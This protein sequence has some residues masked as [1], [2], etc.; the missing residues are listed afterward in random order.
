[1]KINPNSSIR[2]GYKYEDLFTLKLCVDWLLNPQFYRNIRIQYTPI[3][4][5]VKHFALDDIVAQRADGITE[6]Y[7]I[8]HKQNP[9]TDHWDFEQLKEKGLY[10][11]IRSF[12]ALQENKPICT[13]ITNGH[14]AE[15]V[16]N[17]SKNDNLCLAQIKAFQPKI[18]EELLSTF[19]DKDLLNIFFKSFNFKFNCANK[20][21]L[22]YSLRQILYKDLKVTKPGVDNLLLFIESQGSQKYP[23][24]FTL[25]EIRSLLSWDN[26]RPLNQNFEIP[27]DFEFFDKNM[28]QNI[29][30]DLL[31]VKGGIKVF[32]GKPG[33]G[34]STYLSKLYSALKQKG[35]LVFRHHYHL[36]PKDDSYADRL[37]SERAIEGLKAEFKTLD[38]SIIQC[39]GEQNTS[40]TQLK[41]FIDQIA[42]YC[43]TENKTFI[44]IIDGLD[45][46]IREGNS[47]SQLINF[48]TDILYPQRGFWLLLGTQE[49]ATRCFP[50]LI[51]QYAPREQWIEIKGLKR[52][53]I[54]KIAVK[55]FPEDS[56]GYGNH[57]DK[58]ISKLLEIT[59]GNPL[60][61]RYVLTE[62]KNRGNGIS[63][64]ALENIPFYNE[65][66]EDYYRGLWQQLPSL[67]KTISFALTILDFRM[68]NEQVI[69]LASKLCQFPYEITDSFGQIRHLFRFEL[70]GISV[71]HN[72]FLVF[73]HD[74]PELQEQKILL[75]SILKNWLKE[76]EQSSLCWSELPKIEYYLGDPSLLLSINNSWIVEQYLDCK[77]EKTIENTLYLASKAAFE[78]KQ[79]EK[80][81]YFSVV[82][83]LFSN[84]DYNLHKTLRNIWVLSFITNKKST[85]QYPDFETL[86][87]YQL[88]EILI[89]LKK[90]G[91]INYIPD[92][93]INRVN[94]LFIDNGHDSFDVAFCWTKILAFFEEG[95]TQRVFNFLK[96]FRGKTHAAGYFKYYLQKLL[97][98]NNRPLHKIEKLFKTR[99]LKEEKE[100][101]GE[102]LIIDDLN[103]NTDAWKLSIKKLIPV[104]SNYL[105]LYQ[106][107]I[108]DQYNYKPTTISFDKFPTTVDY[109]SS[110]FN[111]TANILIQTLIGAFINTYQNNIGHFENLR[112]EN[113]TFN[114]SWVQKLYLAILEIGSSIAKNFMSKELCEIPI[115]LGPIISLPKLD[116]SENRDIY[117]YKRV[118]LPKII[119]YTL[120]LIT[121]VN[122]KNNH[123]S[124]FNHQNITLLLNTDWYS[125][126]YFFD[127]IKSKLIT[128]EQD[129][130]IEFITVEEGK[131]ENEIQPF[132]DKAEHYT[133]LAFLAYESGND[134]YVGKLLQ[135]A[136]NNIIAYS[137]HKYM[138]LYEI[139]QS[140]EIC[141]ENGTEQGKDFLH[142][143]L[144]Y[145]FNI[146][147]LTDGDETNSFMS[148]FCNLLAKVDHDLL[149]KLYNYYI[150]NR[151]YDEIQETF[152]DILET[153]DY[154]DPVAKAIGAT[155]INDFQTLKK[156]E[157]KNT[158]VKD[159]IEKLIHKY[160]L[161]DD[162]I[163]EEKDRKSVSKNTDNDFTGIKPEQLREYLTKKMNFSGTHFN[164]EQS[165]FLVSWCSIRIAQYPQEEKKIIETLK[166]LL[167]DNFRYINHDL[168]DIIY[169]IAYK[170]DRAFAFDCICWAHSNDSGW[171]PTYIR[172][173]ETSRKRWKKVLNDFPERSEEFYEI[174]L[175]NSGLRYGQKKDY[176]LPIPK[177]TQFYIDNK[178][179]AKAETI[180]RY[181]INVLQHIFPNTKLTVPDFLSAQSKTT[182]FDILLSRLNW[183]SPIIKSCAAEEIAELLEQDLDGN[184]HKIFFNYLYAQSLENKA[185]EGL[186]IIIKSLQ[187]PTSQTFTFLTQTKFRTLTSVR[188]MAS[189][190]LLL[191]IGEALKY[192]FTTEVPLVS[193]L[194]SGKTNMS[195]EKFQLLVSRNVVLWYGDQVDLI[196]KRIKSTIDIW[197]IWQTLFFEECDNYD[198]KYNVSNDE[199]Y[200]NGHYKIMMGRTTIFGDILK[201]TFMRL[202][203]GLYN[204]DL[205]T[206]TELWLN[207]IKTLPVDYSLWKIKTVLIP[208]WWPKI[209]LE[210]S[211]SDHELFDY[212][213]TSIIDI[214]KNHE[215][216][217]LFF[218]SHFSSEHNFYD[219]TTYYHIKILAFACNPEVISELNPS[220]TYEELSESGFWYSNGKQYYN[221]GSLDGKLEFNP[222]LKE[223]KVVPLVSEL[224]GYSNN[225]WQYYRAMNNIVLLSPIFNGIEINFS[226]NQLQFK[227]EKEIAHFGD[228]LTSFTDS[229]KVGEPI[230]YNSY[231]T[232]NR[233]YLDTSLKENKLT[234]AFVI[235]Q[236]IIRKDM[237]D[238]DDR[239]KSN[240]TYEIINLD[241]L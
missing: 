117:E 57:F 30:N 204:L 67:A 7:Q 53:S 54:K 142:E 33:S 81:A 72:S 213:K 179:L 205:I 186:L 109:Y 228:F 166:D 217:P 237:M 88:T 198:L 71:Y 220:K 17:C 138:L 149:Y 70:A 157:N 185:C 91:I 161:Q 34:K 27:T 82:E 48:L 21:E 144:P 165:A 105:L 192:K 78:T 222:G 143:I 50:N 35:I 113:I 92:E 180:T 123:L 100:A 197:K 111:E 189:D 207:T 3:D 85:L 84:R 187:N 159:S 195:K 193:F 60:H 206:I 90:R 110:S 175:T 13:L 210:E 77:S 235:K 63:E 74:Q 87:E 108:N 240:D 23:K 68:Q 131:I 51:N 171:S 230:P 125:K 25:S 231:L 121:V 73:I 190:L 114:E 176:R 18:Y 5:N 208:T 188:C 61:L 155:A 132:P 103:N 209:K 241:E 127:L 172:H 169:P 22:E 43:R 211:K 215:S 59:K 238:R 137:H 196:Q 24:T 98:Q 8:K 216:I 141:I 183:I 236:S 139:L 9:E 145:V 229:C 106:S 101:L 1:M 52:E 128:I 233:E 115:I 225:I 19:V 163:E 160:G 148:N 168:L 120:W 130:V 199:G 6:Y 96:Q 119:N 151:D 200:M 45:H 28:H 99:L 124:H 158:G 224:R 14:V 38:N 64:H 112:K 226:S 41:E 58:V 12:S 69:S 194:S 167:Q 126:A 83:V 32:M 178:N 173:M 116:F 49:M 66:I 191:N 201:S 40:F 156:L 39:L 37:N 29:I 203:D 20:K 10:K 118:G 31:D 80:L 104:H 93:A 153:I 154:N 129:S 86:T 15:E 219:S 232:I 147:N 214:F 239:Y 177:S 227:Q 134:Q 133:N 182:L 47:E 16:L 55:S 164:Y 97:Y 79:L 26:P 4:I 223:L 146:K 150:K 65:E 152:T 221:Y 135:K 184:Y 102:V 202:M 36:N 56:K 162:Q 44:L 46:V 136:A 42:G 174:S 76:A 62:L 11:W 89:A 107:F 234:L 170:Y 140:I 95:N 75:Y 2:S 94:E 218:N 181:Y 122:K 212:K